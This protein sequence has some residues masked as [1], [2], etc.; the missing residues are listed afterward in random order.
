MN[1]KIK[2]LYEECS[3]SVYAKT[4]GY[5]NEHYRRVTN[6]EKFAELIVKECINTLQTQYNPDD[7]LPQKE[8]ELCLK[9]HFGI[10]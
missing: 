8:I 10:E 1:E 3:N 4:D 5:G 2:E 7:E 9:E 6:Y